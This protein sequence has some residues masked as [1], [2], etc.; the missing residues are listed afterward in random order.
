MH[1]PKFYVLY[2][3]LQLK[4]DHYIVS[5]NKFLPDNYLDGGR[6][7]DIFSLTQSTPEGVVYKSIKL[8]NKPL[9]PPTASFPKRR[10]ITPR[11]RG[12]SPSRRSPLKVEFTAQYSEDLKY[13]Y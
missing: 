2:Y 7:P 9:I 8:N 10:G 13:L 11:G 3:L 6:G 1:M 12:H 4:Y 5:N